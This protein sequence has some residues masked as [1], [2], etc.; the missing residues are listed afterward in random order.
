MAKSIDEFLVDLVDIL[1][2]DEELT[3][4]TNL[5]DLEEWDSLSAMALMAYFD[6]NFAIRYNFDEFFLCENVSDI[7]KL[8][9]G[10][11]A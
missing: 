8:T 4:E 2:T 11:V 6:K 7:I 10:N 3:L 9:N 1:Q 5:A